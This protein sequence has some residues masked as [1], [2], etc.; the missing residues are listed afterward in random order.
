MSHK[1]QLVILNVFL[2]V[3]VFLRQNRFEV[4]QD[5]RVDIMRI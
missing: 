3:C 4:P 5:E 1:C 2:N